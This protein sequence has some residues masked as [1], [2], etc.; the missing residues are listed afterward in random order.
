VARYHQPG[1]KSLT[2]DREGR[3]TVD[4]HG[5]RRVVRIEKNG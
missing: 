1:S 5:N 3:L 4:Q 2:L